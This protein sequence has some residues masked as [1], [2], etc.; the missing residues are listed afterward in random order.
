MIKKYGCIYYHLQK[1]QWQSSVLLKR[2]QT[3]DDIYCW[4]GKSA[5]HHSYR[6]GLYN[7]VA[8][9]EAVSLAIFFVN[10]LQCLQWHIIMVLTSLQELNRERKEGIKASKK[11]IARVS[12]L[13][14]S[15]SR[16]H[17]VLIPSNAC[18]A[19]HYGPDTQ[20]VMSEASQQK[21]DVFPYR[22]VVLLKCWSKSSL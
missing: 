20:G 13:F 3:P 11:V 16:V 19:S 10:L 5:S 7:A 21:V 9:D 6:T 8:L 12:F 4:V 17:R 18:P 14:S 22:K 15:S 1:I 2:L